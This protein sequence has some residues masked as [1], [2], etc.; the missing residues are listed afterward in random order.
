MT[1]ENPKALAPE[2]APFCQ[3]E[4][5]VQPLLEKYKSMARS[6]DPFAPL[7]IEICIECGR[8]C[9]LHQHFDIRSVAPRLIPIPRKPDPM[10]P[11]RTVA[12]Y[13]KCTGGGRAELFARILAV[14]DVYKKGGI[15]NP[16]AERIA[17]AETA[18]RA[19]KHPAYLARGKAIADKPPAE[20]TFNTKVPTIKKYDDP[21]Y[22]DVTAE[23]AQAAIVA[24]QNAAENVAVA[25]IVKAGMVG[26]KRRTYKRRMQG[27]QKTNL[28]KKHSES[29]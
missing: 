12:D 6:I 4:Y 24:A 13:A 9:F 21:A 3:S 18:D 5:V 1:H 8:P 7:R 15:K 16:K 20:R 22:E 17:A 28:T 2:H 19:A 27:R 23:N 29:V 14:R 26:G 10:D 11:T 25:A